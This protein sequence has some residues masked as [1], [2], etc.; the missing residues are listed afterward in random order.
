MRTKSRVLKGFFGVLALV[1]CVIA[2]Q[3]DPPKFEQTGQINKWIAQLNDSDYPRRNAAVAFLAEQPGAALPLLEQEL[4]KETDSNRRW[5]IKVAVQECEKNQPRPGEISS[6]PNRSEGLQ[7]CE[8]CK[9][10][11]GLFA[12]VEREGVRCWEVP[13]KGYYLYFSAEER[14]RREAGAALEIQLEYLD[15][16]TGQIGL[17]YDSTD[18]RAPVGGAYENHSTVI[19]CTNSGQWRKTRFHLANARFRG[20]ENN[21]TDFRFYNGGDDMIIRAVRVWPSRASD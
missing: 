20:S 12:V 21:Q 5:W 14:F 6:G 4:K 11:D 19:H 3:P 7:V 2:Q 13:K 8:T 18:Q 17:D 1:N 16:G 10:G 15:I 9:N